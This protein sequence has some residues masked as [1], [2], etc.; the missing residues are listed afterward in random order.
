MAFVS[1][2]QL[3]W[4]AAILVVV[5]LYLRWGMRK[6]FEASTLRIWE[7]AI[8]RRALWSRWR[9]TVSIFAACVPIVL[10][11][12]ALA[13]PFFAPARSSARSIVLVVDA[14]AS[15]NARKDPDRD[16]AQSSRLA[17]A[18]RQARRL[19]GRLRTHETMAIL[20]ADSAVRIHCGL[21]DDRGALHA[22]LDQIQPTDGTGAVAPA[23]QTAKRS[24]QGHGNPVI[25]LLSDGK[26]AGAERWLADEV[27]TFLAPS[28]SAE[29]VAITRLAAR[30][31]PAS[32]SSYEVLVEVA[33]FGASPADV[34]VRL[35]LG[36]EDRQ[37]LK[38][39]VPAGGRAS[40]FASLTIEQAGLLAAMIDQEDALTADNTASVLIVPAYERSVVLVSEKE[41]SPAE[42]A[43][44][45]I[46]GIDLRISAAGRPPDDEAAVNTILVFDEV[47]PQSLPPQPALL[48]A[49]R[50]SSDLWQVDDA[51]LESPQ[52]ARQAEAPLLA[53]VDLT[54]V[55]IDRALRLDLPEDAQ[56]LAASADG[57]PLYARLPRPEGDVLVL[58]FSP[59]ESDFALRDD[60]P[61]LI[62]RAISHLSAA[63]AEAGSG[64]T[65]A[66]V[67]VARPEANIDQ[68]VSPYGQ[69]SAA[70]QG[71][72]SAV[73]LNQAGVWRAEQ[74]S[75]DSTAAALPVN[76]L[77]AAES[78]VSATNA[79]GD[80]VPTPLLPDVG[81]WWSWL[82]GLALVW[83]IG[84]GVF[85]QR[86]VI[87]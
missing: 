87:D 66:D 75:G 28:D 23:L 25:V 60:F 17:A 51:P 30:P 26:F 37:S 2:M 64:W 74:T 55:L 58:A 22:A 63:S 16:D 19:I 42:A 32:G 45:S 84:Q 10:L 12:L 40:G 76:L 7:Q 29:N 47:V 83:V 62:E 71:Q 79:G 56:V 33:N 59:S 15:M 86:R 43:L 6:R 50:A 9:R 39:N 57:D 18:K 35:Q 21:T 14:T 31:R 11:A 46:A 48:M 27:V 4:T 1:P 72:P 52:V 61:R 69:R 13:R 73:L 78:D 20:S 81:P 49:P 68:V 54:S 65:T 5:L 80:R 24:L 3:A 38:L 85:Y 70:K 77:D 67:F 82:V 53:G 36:G 44:R 34:Q 8:A 41:N